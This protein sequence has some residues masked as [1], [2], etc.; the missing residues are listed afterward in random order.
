MILLDFLKDLTYGEFAQLKIGELIAG[1][2]ES[3]PDPSK[4]EQLMSHVNLGL[5]EIYKR[6]FL[7]SKEI[8]IELHEEISEYVIAYKYAQTSGSAEDPQYIMDTAANP[9]RDDLLKI[10]EVYD[11]IGVK[12]PMNDTSEDLSIFTPTYRSIQVP[13]PNDGITYA[14]QYR[15]DHPRLVWSIAIDPSTVEIEVPHSLH[16]ALLNYVAS[17]GFTSLGG[18]AG[19]TEG[20]SYYSKFENSCQKVHDLG[21]EVQAEPGTWRF[22]DN[23]WV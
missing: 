9:F 21:L 17:R 6:F 20:L 23:G 1:E 16:E 11:E 5:T 13:Y 4:Y 7:S 14:V 15:A 3:Q 19:T 22:D 18:E 2:F 8:Y 10:E 12:L